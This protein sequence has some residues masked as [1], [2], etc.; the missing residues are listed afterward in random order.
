MATKHQQKRIAR[1]VDRRASRSLRRSNILS[2]SDSM[3][4]GPNQPCQP[5]LDLSVFK[6][7]FSALM[8]TRCIEY[9]VFKPPS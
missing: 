7:S 3:R 4:L 8:G 1:I 5:A 9:G 2:L 6:L